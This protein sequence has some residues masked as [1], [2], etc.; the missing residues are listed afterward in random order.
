MARNSNRPIVIAVIVFGALALM[1]TLFSIFGKG[2]SPQQV[3]A[4]PTPTPAPVQG[5][6]ATREIPPRTL[7]TG[8]MLE[9][10]RMTQ[11]A[12]L[13]DAVTDKSLAI[14]K[15]SNAE[16]VPGELV[17]SDAL[18]FPLKRVVPASIPIPSGMRG[19]AIWVDPNQTAAGLVDIGDH[20]DVIVDH[21]LHYD[22]GPDEIVHGALD[23][24][25]GRTIAQNLTVLAVD[26]SITEPPPTPTPTP[27]QNGGA[28]AALAGGG[29]PPAPTPTPPPTGPPTPPPTKI[30]V[31][32]AALPQQAEEIVAANE[33]GTIH[34]TIRNPNDDQIKGV[35][36]TSQYP[37]RIVTKPKPRPMAQPRMP[38]FPPPVQTIAPMLPPPNKEVTIIRG[39]EKTRVILPNE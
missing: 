38:N 6:V 22:K 34:L 15:L 8:D 11:A 17:T 27:A 4:A 29:A 13:P 32:L 25:A 37:L 23:F 16:L 26:K 31:L 14:G 39:T 20:V 28:A 1:F 3:A 19:V 7:I 2:G 9:E 30:R 18:T 10:K 35:V 36:E 5:I 24:E 21:K 33:M 12:L